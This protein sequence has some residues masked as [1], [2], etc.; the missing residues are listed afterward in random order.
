[1]ERLLSGKRGV[2]T[3]AAQ[4]IG[5]AIAEVVVSAGGDVVLCDRDPAVQ[6]TAEKLGMPWAE[7]DIT[8]PG[9][10]TGTFADLAGA[11]PLDFLVNNAGIRLVKPLN[12]LSLNEWQ[13]VLAVNLDGTFLCTRAVL[14]T[15][16]A[17]GGGAIVN[18]A[19]VAG[20][21]AFRERPAY[22]ASKAGII[23][24]TKSVAAEHAA[25]GIRCNAVAPGVIETPLTAPYFTDE[26]LAASIHRST[27]AGRWGQPNEIAGPVVF[28]LSEMASFVSGHTLVVDGGWCAAKGY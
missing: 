20:I 5:A 2:V 9:R 22:N 8:D 10:V 28:L 25:D 12:E 3:G 11:G 4:G 27:P 1:L 23:A 13:Q 17:A 6:A 15:M 19:S 14:P 21:L 26:D 18:L 7:L 24:F 16:L